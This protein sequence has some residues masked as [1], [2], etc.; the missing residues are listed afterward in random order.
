MN[1]SISVSHNS[2]LPGA[3]LTLLVAGVSVAVIAGVKLPL[4]TNYKAGLIF[5]L[6][7]GMAVCAPGIGRVA[8]VGG[9]AHPV[10]ILGYLLGVAILV[11]LI[12]GLMGKPLPLINSER[13]ALIAATALVV[14]KML[15]TLVH[16]LLR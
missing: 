14:V 2:M 9:W 7:A 10:S 3:L 16:P 6:I 15:L 4:L 1:T 5:L 12:A 8:A 11:I 13:S